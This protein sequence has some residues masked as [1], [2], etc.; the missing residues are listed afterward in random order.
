MGKYEIAIPTGNVAKA[1]NN[2]V[3]LLVQTIR[4]NILQSH[5]LAAIRDALL[6]KLLSGEIR[7][8]DAEKFVEMAT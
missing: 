7:V 2:K 1:F 3:M 4:T 8:K 6:P 5:T